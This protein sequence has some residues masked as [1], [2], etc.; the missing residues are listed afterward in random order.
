MP[1]K[2]LKVDEHLYDKTVQYAK[3]NGLDN[4]EVA[5]RALRDF[6]ARNS[7]DN[8]I[9]NEDGLTIFEHHKKSVADFNAFIDQLPYKPP[10]VIFV[11]SATHC[12]TQHSHAHNMELIP[13]ELRSLAV[14]WNAVLW[15][16][17][18]ANL[19]RGHEE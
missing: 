15:T 11:D 5:S 13:D 2:A 9:S 4:K 6:F 14:K 17:A 16:G 8:Q 1:S 18:Q 3:K 19:K 7:E 12:T 10:D